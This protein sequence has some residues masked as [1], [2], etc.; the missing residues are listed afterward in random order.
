MIRNPQDLYTTSFLPSRKIRILLAIIIGV[1]IL[2]WLVPHVWVWVRTPGTGKTLPEPINP[3]IT[4]PTDSYLDSD[5][6]GIP[7]WKEQFLKNYGV[8]QGE[9]GESSASETLALLDE[10]P[11]TQKIALEIAAQVE[12]GTIQDTQK[13]TEQ[14]ISE[15]IQR[16]GSGFKTYTLYDISLRERDVAEDQRIY[17]EEMKKISTKININL[18][19]NEVKKIIDLYSGK[20]SEEKILTTVLNNI[21]ANIED[22]LKIPVPQSATEIH[23]NLLNSLYVFHQTLS[24]QIPRDQTD[25]IRSYALLTLV[26]KNLYTIFSEQTNLAGYFFITLD[27][28]MY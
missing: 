23:L 22:L 6:D 2:V 24:L 17:A 11:D 19:T 28:S 27:P 26:Q 16:L 4:T 25:P 5:D 7:D 8:I 10:I 21:H 9:D 18:G 14:T 15:Y 3:T 20:S 13:I 12:Q 1:A